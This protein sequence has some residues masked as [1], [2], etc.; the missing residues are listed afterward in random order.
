M[1]D[2]STG[3]ENDVMVAPFVFP[4]LAHDSPRNFNRN[5]RQNYKKKSAVVDLLTKHFFFPKRQVIFTSE[6]NKFSCV[7]G[8]KRTGNFRS[9]KTL[10]FGPRLRANPFL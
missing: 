5:G 10:F 2:K 4:F 7:Y 6:D 3:Q 1:L 9:Y 8:I